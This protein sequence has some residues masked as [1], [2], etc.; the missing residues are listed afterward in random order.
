MTAEVLKKHATAVM[1]ALGTG[2]T[3]SVYHRAM[4]TSLNAKMIPHRSEVACPVMFMGEIV[5]TGRADLVVGDLVIELKA[6]RKCPTEASAQLNKYVENLT[7]IEG[8]QYRGMIINFGQASQL[9]ETVEQP[10]RERPATV[11]KSRFFSGD[12]SGKRKRVD[13]Y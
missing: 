5:G 9:V 10:K 2:H 12:K 3:E 1:K 8:R 11:V 13:R 6:N 7:E 4:V